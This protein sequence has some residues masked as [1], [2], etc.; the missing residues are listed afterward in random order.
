MHGQVRAVHRPR[1]AAVCCKLCMG[2]FA[3][4][5]DQEL[6]QVCCEMCMGR[7]ALCIDQELLASVLCVR[8]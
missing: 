8:T 7:L 2:R 1:A 3:L 4:Y 5:T 6:L